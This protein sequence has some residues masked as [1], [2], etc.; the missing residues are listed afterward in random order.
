MTVSTRAA[1]PGI[2]FTWRDVPVYTKLALDSS[3]I[4]AIA[5]SDHSP[6]VMRIGSQ[7]PGVDCAAF[8]SCNRGPGYF[9]DMRGD[10]GAV[11]ASRVRRAVTNDKKNVYVFHL[12]DQAYCD[13]A[14]TDLVKFSEE[15]G[16]PS[17]AEI[18]AR[19]RAEWIR[20]WKTYAL[21]SSGVHM[22]VADDHE[23]VDGLRFHPNMPPLSAQ[24]LRIVAVARA[25]AEEFMPTNTLAAKDRTVAS[26]SGETLFMLQIHR[27]YPVKVSRGEF[28]PADDLQLA[29]QVF[30]DKFSSSSSSSSSS[31]PPSHVVVLCPQPPVF[32]STDTCIQ[33]CGQDTKKNETH[34][35]WAA[36]GFSASLGRFLSSAFDWQGGDTEKRRVSF[37]AGDMHTAVKTRISDSRSTK[38]QKIVQYTASP[39]MN[40]VSA[41]PLVTSIQTALMRAHPVIRVQDTKDEFAY[42]HDLIVYARNF[43]WWDGERG[44]RGERGE[45]EEFMFT[46]MDNSGALYTDAAKSSEKEGR[47]GNTPI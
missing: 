33:L 24:E 19:F 17:D 8:V 46:F 21:L 18:A 5:T 25:V 34:F 36:Q 43:L 7:A 40:R 3:P 16:E 31:L 9:S 35:F 6:A 27:V 20:T 23:V 44:E 2:P 15:R 28:L 32:F 13:Q 4:W 30:N 22:M 29:D 41:L 42:T 12:G 38:G 37:I 14:Y 39:I 45:K 1:V 47:G 11:L 26:R 10:L